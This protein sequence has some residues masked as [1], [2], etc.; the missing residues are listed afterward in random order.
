MAKHWLN[1]ASPDPQLSVF[2]C[3]YD[4]KFPSLHLMKFNELSFDTLGLINTVH[5]Y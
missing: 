3:A 4:Y 2:L 1:G 5:H